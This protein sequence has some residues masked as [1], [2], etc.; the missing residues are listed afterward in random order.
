[1]FIVKLLVLVKEAAERFIVKDDKV[2]ILSK[3]VLGKFPEPLIDRLDVADALNVPE[4][5]MSPFKVKFPPFK[6]NVPA[7]I[8]KE[9]AIVKSFPKVKVFAVRL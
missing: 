7:D 2:V 1:M 9:F 3:S 5:V 4:F 8:I 6:L